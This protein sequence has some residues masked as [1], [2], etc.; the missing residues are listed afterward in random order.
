M[1][2]QIDGRDTA[3]YLWDVKGVVPFLKIDKGLEAE[4]NG[5]QLMKPMPDLD[6]LLARGVA[7]GIFGTKERSVVKLAN[8]SGVQAIVDQQFKVGRQVLGAGLV[9]ILEPE[10]DIKS[11]EKAEAETQLK[12]AILRGLDDLSGDEEVM[13]KLTLP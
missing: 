13:F 9:P 8:E 4:A 12:A 6:K 5:V 1:D 2:R 10:V 11:P 3:E 7:K